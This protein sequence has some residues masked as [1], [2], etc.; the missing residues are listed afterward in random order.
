[1]IVF[2]DVLHLENVPIVKVC[3]AGNLQFDV[4]NFLCFISCFDD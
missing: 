1:M 2:K 4:L 3:I